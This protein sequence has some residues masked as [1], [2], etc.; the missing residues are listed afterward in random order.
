M[1][2]IRKI[3]LTGSLLLCFCLAGLAVFTSLYAPGPSQAKTAVIVALALLS[4]LPVLF[5]VLALKYM[6]AFV[7]KAGSGTRDALTD[8]YNKATFWDFLGYEIERSRRQKYRFSIM[9]VD[10]DDFKSINDR[11]GHEAGDAYLIQFSNILRSAVRKGDIVARYGGD[12]FTAIL[13]VC[14]EAQAYIAGRR[15]LDGLRD[16]SLLLPD[17]TVASITASVGLAVYPD[18]A[19]DAESLFL[20]AD[21]M[22]H[23][24]KVSGKDKVSLP[25]DEVD[26]ELLKN[27]GQKSL[28]IMDAVRKQRFV[29]Y[30]QP[31]VD[32]KDQTIF[33]YEVLT[34]IITPER[35]IPAAEFIEEAEGM[36][37]IGKIDC[38]LIEQAFDTV[39]R[40]GYA[41]K[42]FFNLSPKALVLNDF[43][44]TMRKQMIAYGFE[45]S[46]LVFEITERDTVKNLNMLGSAIYDLKQEGFQFAIDDFG[47]GYSS[48]QYLKLFDVDFLKVDGEFIRDMTPDNSTAQIIVA[49]ISGLASRLGI[50]TIAEYVESEAILG[51]VLSAGIDYAQGHHTGYPQP[52]LPSCSS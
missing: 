3:I 29:P 41:G 19:K 14:D 7:Q 32:V 36:G 35:V 49:N 13:P 46:Q 18:H 5:S 44:P 52:D 31:I 40:R 26:V 25:S 37:M 28:F 10:L 2:K 24:A 33:A 39:K 42:L 45:P 43:M 27:A 6:T 22:L 38:Q 20:L 4:P 11:Y 21:S 48:F 17:G 9:L 8:L 23:Q 1:K 15:L 51:N 50:K 12:N 34:R 16:Q 47:S 30:F